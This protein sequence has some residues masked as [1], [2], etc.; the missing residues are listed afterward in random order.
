MQLVRIVQIGCLVLAAASFA[1]ARAG[2][3]TIGTASSVTLDAQA[4]SGAGD[5]ASAA[6]LT[7]PGARAAA[8]SSF[9]VGHV[10]LAAAPGHATHASAL[11]ADSFLLTGGGGSADLSFHLDLEGVL[12]AEASTDGFARVVLRA[13]VGLDPV[14]P[15]DDT[16]LGPN[17]VLAAADLVLQSDLGPG[18]N[19]LR[20]DASLPYGAPF[21]FFVT[22]EAL[23]ENGAWVHF[24]D[25]ARLTHVDL[26]NGAILTGASGHDYGLGAVSVASMSAVPEPGTLLLVA[27]GTA[28][29]ASSG[30]RRSP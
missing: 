6:S 18:A 21:T 26:P 10:A 29:L 1:P 17:I 16:E 11:W 25:T 20:L 5:T 3:V 4:A 7:G 24:A 2:A 14:D 28:A 30:S 9:G 19:E 12:A 13:I 22:L 8:A 27:L 15:I 23:A